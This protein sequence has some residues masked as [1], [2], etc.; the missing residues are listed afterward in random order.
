M[1][2]FR[3][4]L[5]LATTA[6]TL[7]VVG[8][9]LPSFAAPDNEAEISAAVPMPEPANLPP[10]SAAD[11]VPLGTEPATGATPP[12]QTATATA[13]APGNP[14]AVG[15]PATTP[16]AAEAPPAPTAEPPVLTVDQH[17]GEK[18][19]DLFAG[20]FERVI[21]RRYKPAVE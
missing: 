15:A 5:L 6:L 21:D 16:A 7:V 2:G 3:F 14:P 10:P 8:S 1:R 11:L 9:G 20:K 12:A 13:G 17:I 4:E 19:R 18:I